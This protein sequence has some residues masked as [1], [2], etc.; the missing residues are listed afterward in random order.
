MLPKLPPPSCMNGCVKTV[1]SKM[2]SASKKKRVVIVDGYNVLRSGSRYKNI[3]TP[4]YTDD[5][6]NTAR[7]Q[8]LND[9]AAFAGQDAQI[10]VVFDGAGNARSIGSVEK[11]GNIQVIFSAA[12][13]QADYVIEKL[14]YEARGRGQEVTVIS[15]DSAIQNTVYSAGVDR[16]SAE[17]FSR[18]M[19]IFYKQVK[20]DAKPEI[21]HKHTV[22]D[23]IDPEV[24]TRL[25]KLRDSSL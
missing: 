10:T 1:V 13:Q 19:Q 22:A 15:S 11:I 25:Q 6:F 14:A 17:G 3:D 5:F 20:E 9:V 8:L 18:E 2:N 21:S 16:M 23:R 4:D 12:G 7:E 24:L